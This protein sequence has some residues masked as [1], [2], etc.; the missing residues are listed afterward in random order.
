MS[1]LYETSLL[2][3]LT[4]HVL[5]FP[6]ETWSLLVSVLYA[7]FWITICRLLGSSVDYSE[8]YGGSG[9]GV[10]GAGEGGQMDHDEE[11]ADAV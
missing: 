4:P 11:E 8:V 9:G 6:D 5:Q 10:I 3:S 7:Y 1:Y 2:S